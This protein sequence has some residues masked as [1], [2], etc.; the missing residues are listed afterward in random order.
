[1]ED[2]KDLLQPKLKGRIAWTDSPREFVGAALQTLGM[3][4]NSTAADLK[5]AGIPEADLA[6]AVAR[7]RKQVPSVAALCYQR[8]FSP[9]ILL[10]VKGPT[11]RGRLCAHLKS[12]RPAVHLQV[13]AL[14]MRLYSGKIRLQEA[15]LTDV[16]QMNGTCCICPPGGCVHLSPGRS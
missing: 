16:E 12:S 2:W 10:K 9:V 11:V 14:D 4:F 13:S 7:L 1:M 3:H 5:A 15:A 6:A 8:A